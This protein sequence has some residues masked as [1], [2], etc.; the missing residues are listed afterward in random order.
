MPIQILWNIFALWQL[1]A[2]TDKCFSYF[3]LSLKRLYFCIC[4]ILVWFFFGFLMNALRLPVFFLAYFWLY[5]QG[6]SLFHSYS[7]LSDLGFL[8]WF[9]FP[10]FDIILCT[11][12]V[13]GSV[14]R[15]AYLKSNYFKLFDWNYLHVW[16][17]FSFCTDFCGCQ[18]LMYCNVSK[19]NLQI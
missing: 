13:S 9:P 3:L 19:Y 15:G 11:C 5:H 4:F 7:S 10:S 6:F 1:L 8:F 16:S 18:L 14:V 2:F 17:N 12:Y